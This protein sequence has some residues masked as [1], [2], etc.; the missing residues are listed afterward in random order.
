MASKATWT[1]SRSGK[2]HTSPVF[3]TDEMALG[4]A[5]RQPHAK[6]V[7]LVASDAVACDK[8][9]ACDAGTAEKQ[10]EATSAHYRGIRQA[11]ELAAG[12]RPKEAPPTR[13]QCAEQDMETYGAAYLAT[14]SSEAAME[15]LNYVRANRR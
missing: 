9:T 14:G 7:R 3:G 5:R 6:D 4:Y 10:R 8:V 12:N 2:A 15:E 1:D 13:E 11:N